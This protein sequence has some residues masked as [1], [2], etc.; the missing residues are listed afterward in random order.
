[1][2]LL[3]LCAFSHRRPDFCRGGTSLMLFANG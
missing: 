3:S 2:I 1:M